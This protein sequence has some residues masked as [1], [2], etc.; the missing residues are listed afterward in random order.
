M[1][2]LEKLFGIRENRMFKRLETLY[3][4]F[5]YVDANEDKINILEYDMDNTDKFI[6]FE[7]KSNLGPVR[8][9]LC[10]YLLMELRYKLEFVNYAGANVFKIVSTNC[11]NWVEP[12]L[13]QDL[14]AKDIDL[15]ILELEQYLQNKY[16]SVESVMKKVEQS[17]LEEQSIIKLHDSEVKKLF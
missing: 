15:A 6:Y 12:Y 8:I 4:Y 2:L 1:G 7:F 10:R 13:G 14:T 9:S 5:K 11:N 3:Y 16:G 17:K